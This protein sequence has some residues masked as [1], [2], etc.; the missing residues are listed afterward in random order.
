MTLTSTGGILRDRTGGF[1]GGRLCGDHHEE[2]LG[3]RGREL[4]VAPWQGVPE[5]VLH[6][7]KAGANLVGDLRACRARPVGESERCDLGPERRFG[8]GPLQRQEVVPVEV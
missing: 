2:S 1:S 7:V 3:H 6:E 5:R 8:G 4:G